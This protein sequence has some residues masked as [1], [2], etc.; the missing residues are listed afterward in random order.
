[1]LQIAAER[2]RTVLRVISS[3][4]DELLGLRRQLA[5]QLLVSQTC[6]ERIHLQID[7]LD[8]IFLRQRLIEDDLV[9]T[10]QELGAERTLQQLLD[11]RTGLLGDLAIVGNAVQ[12]IL[13]AEVARQDQDRILEVDGA[14]LRIGDTAVV[15]HLQQDVEDVGM[16]L[17]DLVEQHDAVRLAV[18][19]PPSS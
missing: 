10:V 3:V 18:S 17:F 2:T 6:I 4:D 11:L 8:D 7:D 12:Q 9:Q 19:W 16:G 15:K 1:M 13:R 14:A 5:A